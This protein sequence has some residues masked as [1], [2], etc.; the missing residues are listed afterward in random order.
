MIN[1]NQIKLKILT[2]LSFVCFSIPFTIYG[3]WIFSF[4]LGTTQAEKASIFKAH[5][6]DFLDGRWTLT[7]LSVIFSLT[8]IVISSS[9]IRQ[10]KKTW[11][12]VNFLIIIISSI[13]LFLNLFSMI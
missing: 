3:I 10:L 13:L 7:I 11:K 1:D 4:N 2:L 9:S 12:S 8:A 6:P 5:F